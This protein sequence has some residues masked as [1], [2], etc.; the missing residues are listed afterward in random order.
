MEKNSQDA[1]SLLAQKFFHSDTTNR[2][3]AI[4]ELGIKLGALFHQ[5]TGS[6]ISNNPQQIALLERGI[7]TSIE[8]QPYVSKVEVKINPEGINS[9]P[10]SEFDYAEVNRKNLSATI[11][12]QYENWNVTG[13]LEWIS[14]LNYPLMYIHEIRSV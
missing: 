1:K 3:R 14:E 5:F 13:K 8:S 12:L 4:F 2:D 9:N 7:E 11:Q 6:P 10:S